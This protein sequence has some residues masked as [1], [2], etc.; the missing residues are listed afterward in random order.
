MTTKQIKNITVITGTRADYGILRSVIAAI[1]KHPKLNLQIIATG[2]H[3]LKKFGHT[4][5]EI[6]TDGYKINA[7]IKLQPS[8]DCM[9]SQA[10]AMGKAISQLAKAYRDLETDIVLVLGDRLEAF[11]AA[12]AAVACGK[13]LAHIHGGDAAQGIQDDSYRHAITKLAHIHFPACDSSAKRIIKLG[14]EKSRIYQ[15]GSPSIDNLSKNICRS[16]STLNQYADFDIREKF[17]IILQHPIGQKPEIEAQYMLDTLKACHAKCR[18]NIVLYP[19]SDSGH[20]AIIDAA[21]PYCLSHNLKFIKH[22]PRNIFLGLLSRCQCLVGNSSAG[23]V[24]T[25]ALN[26]DVINIGPRQKG[27][28]QGKY[29]IDCD[30]GQKNVE[31]A[32]NIALKRNKNNRKP[33]KIYGIGR[34]GTKIAAVLAKTKISRELFI[35]N[36][37]Y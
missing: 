18:N 25:S 26:V 22:L 31:K 37:C 28:Q 15:T 23:I 1:D 4:I 5:N 10:I 11:A 35:K 29:V 30:Y 21:K 34:S 3:L 19:N 6:K 9:T 7:E 16:I 13:C 2:Q 12:S 8:I 33:C 17:L 24:E 36:I 14:E 27:R 32:L 20:A